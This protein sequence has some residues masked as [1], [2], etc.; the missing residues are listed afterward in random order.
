M[1][2]EIVYG[3]LHALAIGGSVV[4]FIV[5][6]VTMSELGAGTISARFRPWVIFGGAL[7][8]S[9]SFAAACAGAAQPFH[10]VLGG[11]LGFALTFGVAVAAYKPVARMLNF[12]TDR[13]VTLAWR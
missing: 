10:S 3:A 7:L 1:M 8:C 12:L 13:A 5:G 11:A 9:G 2:I 4:A 6:A